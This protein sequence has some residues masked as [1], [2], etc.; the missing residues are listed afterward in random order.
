MVFQTTGA[1]E[2]LLNQTEHLQG[3]IMS[4]SPSGEKVTFEDKNVESESTQDDMD[5]FFDTAP[6]D[7]EEKEKQL[8]P[9]YVTEI[10]DIIFPENQ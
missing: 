3:S 5:F 4:E 2:N 8:D 7:H 10:D 9:R 1:D 6:N